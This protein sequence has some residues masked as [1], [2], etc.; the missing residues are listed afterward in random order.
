MGGKSLENVSKMLVRIDND[1]HVHMYFS[2]MH[3]CLNKLFSDLS[4]LRDNLLAKIKETKII[5]L[6][7]FITLHKAK[8]EYLW[9]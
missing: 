2:D 5:L 6:G 8:T 3:V 4:F 1:M 7:T 9:R